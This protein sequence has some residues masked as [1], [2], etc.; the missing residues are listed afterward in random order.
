[1]VLSDDSDDSS[2]E[3]MYSLDESEMPSPRRGDLTFRG[4]NN[5]TT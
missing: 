4:V 1:M 5:I 2:D 3:S